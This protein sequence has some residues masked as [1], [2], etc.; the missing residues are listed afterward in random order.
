MSFTKRKRQDPHNLLTLIELRYGKMHEQKT[1]LTMREGRLEQN[2]NM[3]LSRQIR[4]TYIL[5]V[6]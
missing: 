4:D 3:R 2:F 6:N 1:I 5:I